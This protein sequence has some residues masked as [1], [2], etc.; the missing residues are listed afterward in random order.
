MTVRM[1][2]NWKWEGSSPWLRVKDN[3]PILTFLMNGIKSGR[4]LEM[5]EVVAMVTCQRQQAYNLRINDS[6]NER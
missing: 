2:D 4:Q 3:R 1:K 5:V 6:E